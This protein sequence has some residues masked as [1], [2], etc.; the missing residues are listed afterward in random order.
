MKAAARAAL[1]PGQVRQL[2]N[3]SFEGVITL[4]VESQ[5]SVLTNSQIQSLRYTEFGYLNTTQ[6]IQLSQSQLISIPDWY[7]LSRIP[8]QVRAALTPAQI[9]FLSN[10]S[11]T[12]VL[13]LL[14]EFQRQFLTMPQISSIGYM[15]FGYLNAAQIIQLNS[16]QVS[17]IPDW[18]WLSRI[19]DS[20][21][22]A[23]TKEQV[24]QL[25]NLGSSGVITLLTPNQ[26]QALTES[27]VKTLLYVDFGYI[28]AAQVVSL[29]PRQIS[30]IPDFYWLSRIAPAAL[31]A[32]TTSQIEQL[33]VRPSGMI[34]L[35]TVDQRSRLLASQVTQL[36]FADFYLLPDNMVL[37]L[38][39]AQLLSIPNRFTFYR[40]STS[41]VRIL[42]LSG[43][44]WVDGVGVVIQR[45]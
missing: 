13:S 18:Y 23:M 29:S 38:S 19:P 42:N 11:G 41:A 10:L 37:Q 14:T 33:N 12:G 26:R 39:D 31:A 22:S 3:L 16:R 28:N 6:I 40:F 45:A 34:S 2:T 9:P 1:L 44:R 43:V 4:L 35:L 30:S 24:Q 7:W 21:R 20:V 27:Q 25:T 32:L 17:S 15:D 8:N 36:T 5:R